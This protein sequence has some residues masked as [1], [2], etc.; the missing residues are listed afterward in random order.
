MASS[1][2]AL[3]YVSTDTFR[4][5]M[6]GEAEMNGFRRAVS[7]AAVTAAL[8]LVGAG[9]ANAFAWATSSS[10]LTV[11]GGAG[12]GNAVSTSYNSGV[13]QSWLKDTM[14]DGART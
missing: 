13:L 1:A 2:L 7:A 11:A 3:R 10:P 6:E 4:Q 14:L 5:T 9:G 8:G 12:Y